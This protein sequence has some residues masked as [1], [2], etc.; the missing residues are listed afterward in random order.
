MNLQ[1]GQ[2]CVVLS[3][4]LAADINV[5]FEEINNTRVQKLNGEKVENLRHMVDLV[6]VRK[7]INIQ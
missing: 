5:G 2:Q 1:A 3:Q 4:V 6:Q 7:K